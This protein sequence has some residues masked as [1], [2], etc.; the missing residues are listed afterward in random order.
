MI[1][2]LL[3]DD[4]PILREGIRSV[5]QG[6][7]S[8]E[9]VGIAV[10]GR[11]ALHMIQ[12]FN[13]DVLV[14][15]IDMPIMTGIDVVRY[16]RGMGDLRPI[17]ILSAYSDAVYVKRV[18]ELGVSGYLLKV[19]VPQ[20]IIAAVLAVSSGETGWFSPA[21]VQQMLAPSKPQESAYRLSERESQVLRLAA[22]GL[23]NKKIANDLC[24]SEHTVKNHF[25]NIHQKLGTSS[26]AEAISWAWKNGLATS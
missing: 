26:H 10:N 25:T 16:L 2:V 1:R 20:Q 11:E 3:A 15:D 5:L 14:L 13:P 18:M 23:T 4:H 9:V 6:D 24:I 8:I 22:Q 19:E 21:I 17:L 7:P 12:D